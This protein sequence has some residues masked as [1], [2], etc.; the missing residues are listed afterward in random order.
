MPESSVEVQ[1]TGDQ[2]LIYE[3]YSHDMMV[4]VLRR[5]EEDYGLQARQI[6]RSPCG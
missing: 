5:A 4:E 3:F 2:I 1:V 6:F